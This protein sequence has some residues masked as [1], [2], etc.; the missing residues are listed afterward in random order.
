MTEIKDKNE[1]VER[2][3]ETNPIYQGA[4]TIDEYHRDTENPVFTTKALK[5]FE[6]RFLKLPP[7]EKK[8]LVEIDKEAKR[9]YSGPTEWEIGT[10][11]DIIEYWP[12]NISGIDYYEDYYELSDQDAI[13]KRLDKLEEMARFMDFGNSRYQ[14]LR[15]EA[16]KRPELKKA[17]D[18]RTVRLSKLSLDVPD[19]DQELKEIL[20]DAI[21]YV[22]PPI[23]ETIDYNAII[24]RE[25]KAIKRDIEKIEA[26]IKLGSLEDLRKGP[27][28]PVVDCIDEILTEEIYRDDFGPFRASHENNR[29]IEDA[30]ERIARHTIYILLDSGL[31]PVK[32]QDDVIKITQSIVDLAIEEQGYKSGKWEDPAHPMTEDEALKQE[33]PTTMGMSK[34]HPYWAPDKIVVPHDRYSM[35]VKGPSIQTSLDEALIG[36]YPY[37]NERIEKGKII[38]KIETKIKFLNAKH[39]PTTEDQAL[40]STIASLQK[41]RN[42]QA[43]R[44]RS[45]DAPLFISENELL[46]CYYGLEKKEPDKAQKD[47]LF[48]WT[49]DKAIERVE[50][51]FSQIIKEYPEVGNVLDRNFPNGQKHAGIKGDYNLPST[52]DLSKNPRKSKKENKDG[53]II[54]E[55]DYTRWYYFPKFPLTIYFGMVL[56]QSSLLDSS[57]RDT[58]TLKESDISNPR[59]KHRLELLENEGYK[60]WKIKDGARYIS[61][62]KSPDFPRM[63]WTILSEIEGLTADKNSYANKTG[64]IQMDP[65]EIALRVWG[66]CPKSSKSDHKRYIMTYLVYLMNNPNSKVQD[67]EL[68]TNKKR[69]TQIKITL[70]PKRI[71]EETE[72][73]KKTAP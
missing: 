38:P 71:T 49:Q 30:K 31:D 70:K 47:W 13:A 68:Y 24:D 16:E 64:F 17:M 59:V 23:E 9:L 20:I 7:E 56:N 52:Y 57:L 58:P 44:D 14:E 45:L 65:D 33:A 15:K 19:S 21:D 43:Y 63:K 66:E 2:T 28:T 41:T 61:L 54:E 4:Y 34:E 32:N 37:R 69:K 72:N 27:Y 35:S 48:K 18:D 55:Y 10:L 46:Q 26:V 60:L 6:T 22:Y 50:M 36:V 12:G 67:I 3:R 39:E 53:T 73:N 29:G 11:G 51:D 40:A 42:P 5:D 25:I 1:P 62:N 8:R